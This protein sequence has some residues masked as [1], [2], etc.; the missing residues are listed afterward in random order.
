MLCF[1]LHLTVVQSILITRVLI[2][3]L[4]AIT[5]ANYCFTAINIRAESRRSDGGIF[6]KNEIGH[7]FIN[8][9]FNLPLPRSI[10]K[11]SPQLPFVLVGEAFLT[12]FMMR[13]YP[14]IN[15]LNLRQ[16][17]FNYRL[18]RARR[19]VECA[20]DIFTAR[21]I[22]RQS[23]LTNIDNAITIVKATVVCKIF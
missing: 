1:R 12:S 7:H 19:I 20:F 4:L 11:N 8:N 10:V 14:H 13:L 22:F 16:K 6:V 2:A 18:S 23:L 21:R 3:V 15:D 17:V 9:T 5:D